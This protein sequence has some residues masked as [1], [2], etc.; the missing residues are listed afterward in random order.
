MRNK[1]LVTDGKL[2]EWADYIEK[3]IPEMKKI[4]DGSISQSFGEHV[5]ASRLAAIALQGA[6]GIV[7]QEAL[8]VLDAMTVVYDETKGAIVKMDAA[9]KRLNAECSSISIALTGIQRKTVEINDY[10][11]QVERLNNSLS[12]FQKHIDSGLFDISA[13]C[14]AVINNQGTK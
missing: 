14:A 8:L 4:F 13:K 5:A 12:Q 6:R 3:S 7:E 9:Q 10:A 1:P 11:T 2:T